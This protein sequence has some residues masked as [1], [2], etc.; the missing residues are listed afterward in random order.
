MHKSS[1]TGTR[2][3][4]LFSLIFLGAV[5]ALIIL[6]GFFQSEAGDKRGAKAPAPV[7]NIEKEPIYDIREHKSDV[8][9]DAMVK[10]R[11]SVGKDASAVANVRED[12]ARGEANLKSRLPHV[13]VEYNTDIRTPEVIT[14]DVYKAKIEFLSPPS[15]E[16]RSEILRDFI[17]ENASLAGVSA[18]QA[19]QL[20]VAA[21]IQIRTETFP[22]LI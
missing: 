22:T 12:F 3:G 4:V 20:T 8:I 19:D 21:D 18:F 15:S 1:I 5:T 16:K 17:K 9:V 6:P 11:Q 10:F 14:P 7:V 2:L 13:K